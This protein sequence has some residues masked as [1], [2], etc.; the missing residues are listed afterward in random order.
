MVLSISLDSS[1]IPY[2]A[3]RSRKFRDVAKHIATAILNV[4]RYS[5]CLL[6]AAAVL[7]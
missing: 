2:G 5:T 3:S 7:R 6:P 1:A 4:G